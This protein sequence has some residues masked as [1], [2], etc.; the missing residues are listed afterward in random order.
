MEKVSNRYIYEVRDKD[1]KI[2]ERAFVAE[3]TEVPNI[4]DVIPFLVG[5]AKVYDRQ[6]KVSP[7]GVP[8]VV[9][10]IEEVKE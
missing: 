8:Y 5:F 7:K 1:D 3:G 10:Y 4:G 6:E 2:Y 9:C